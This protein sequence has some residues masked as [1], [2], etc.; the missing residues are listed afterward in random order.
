MKKLLTITLIAFGTLLTGCQG[1]LDPFTNDI[2]GSNHRDPALAPYLND[3]L[4][5]GQ[6]NGKF[7]SLPKYL[8]IQ[9]TENLNEYGS[10]VIGVCKLQKSSKGTVVAQVLINSTYWN[11]STTNDLNKRALMFHELAH[12]IQFRGH[13]DREL[14]NPNIPASLMNTYALSHNVYGPHQAYYDKE[15][16]HPGTG[17]TAPLNMKLASSIPLDN[18]TNEILDIEEIAFTTDENGCDH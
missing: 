7:L 16:Y 13:D 1:L 11:R 18:E 10:R 5:T 6:I 17:Y 15:L 9:F 2:T 8:S 12:C 3:Y 14:N 4:A